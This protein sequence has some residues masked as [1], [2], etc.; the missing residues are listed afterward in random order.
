MSK[1]DDLLRTI[2]AIHAA[3]LDATRWPDA[4]AAATSLIGGAGATFE[5]IDR[6][7]HR[8]HD[9]YGWGIPE[10]SEVAYLAEYFPLSPRPAMGFRL[11]SGGICYDE[12]VLDKRALGRDP[13]YMEF[14]AQYGFRYFISV[15]VV[16]TAAEAA[17]FAIQRTP[18]QGHVGTREI[19]LMRALTPHLQQA[20]DVSRRLKNAQSGTQALERAFDWLADGAMLVGADG[21]VAYVNI[22]MQ[23]ILR[24]NDGIRL[25]KRRL[26]F[27]DNAAKT[28]YTDALAAV[29]CRDGAADSAGRDIAAIRAGNAPPYLISVRP[30][31]Q[32]PANPDASRVA[33]V[34]VHDVQ[35][36]DS[37]STHA[38]REL[39]GLTQAEA[40][41]AH[42]LQ[43]GTTLSDY[44]ESKRLSLNT[45]YTHLRRI[46][47]KT[48][49]ARLPDL[50]R[51]L[52]EMQIRVRRE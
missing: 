5:V 15:N 39:F 21:A 16:Q 41:L 43:S 31:H 22:A 18:K 12:M 52:S 34:F 11:A 14:L 4:L 28:R 38:L 1:A 37:T 7:N 29:A 25:V 42:A 40:A 36:R 32:G 8:P 23:E 19:E 47:D 48:G 13:F 44:A 49:A 46:K 6:L 27:S 50:I 33:I 10:A 20:Y 2:E 9:W 26:E 51:K 30:L 35:R 24:R 17:P 45:V 3:G